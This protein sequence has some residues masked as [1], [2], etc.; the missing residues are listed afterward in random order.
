VDLFETI[1]N[2]SYAGQIVTEYIITAAMKLTTRM[3]E[4]VQIERLRRLLLRYQTNLDVEIQQRSVEYVNLFGHDQ[5]RRGVLEKMPAPEIREEQ[6]VLGEATK[7]RHS[8]VAK[9][10]PSQTTGEDMLLDL[11][12]GSDMPASDFNNNA[13]GS[14]N[15]ANLLADILGDSSLSS[16][17]AQTT[18]PPPKSNVSSIMDLFDTPSTTT[19][20]PTVQQST[21]VDLF[22]G[23]SSPPRPQ[24]SSP[25]VSGPPAHPAYNKNNLHI[26][27]QLQRN[28]NAV[29]VLARF[30]NT[31]AFDHLS[32]VSLQ[33]AVPKS[34]KLQLQPISQG[35][36]DGGQEATQQ[37][38]VTAVNGVCSSLS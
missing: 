16:P 25:P 36:L 31:G 35:E 9:K 24:A 10:K 6:R 3:S 5:V 29:Q 18:S 15:N 1:L 11:M 27:F 23:M 19:P 8:K 2:S 26:T 14:Q 22:G 38:R 21:N 12:G 20:Q 7:K 4:A 33:A 37:M 34:Q 30:R 32:A 13:N 17:A 28:A